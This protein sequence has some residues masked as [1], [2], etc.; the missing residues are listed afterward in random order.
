MPASRS[1]R[2]RPTSTPHS[3]G[4]EIVNPGHEFG[5]RA[6]PDAQIDA[7]IA[8]C[9]D[10][11][12]PRP[13]RRTASSAH[14]DVA[15]AARTIPASCSPG[16]GW[17]RP[18]SAAGSSRRRSRGH[19]AEDRRRGST[20]SRN[21]RRALPLRL[22]GRRH[23]SLRPGDR[24]NRH[25][26]PAPL[27]AGARRRHRGLFDGHD[28]A[29]LANGVGSRFLDLAGA[30]SAYLQRG[31]TAG[32]PLVPVP[33]GGAGGKSGLHG[34]TVPGNARRGRP[35]GKCHREQTARRAPQGRGGQ[36]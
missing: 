21:C 16:S 32:R 12:A 19:R 24:R 13:F 3:I 14:S 6:F 20:A 23:Q 17:P 27:P 22:R 18:A 33:K 10:I 36:G 15:P 9:R 25:G 30:E 35:Q 11:R 2:A 26:V 28:L 5:Y 29:A 34:H 1:G 8:L 31:Q 4:I 7:V